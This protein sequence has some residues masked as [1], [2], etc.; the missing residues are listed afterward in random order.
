MKVAVE[1]EVCDLDT[2]RNTIK[3]GVMHGLYM[4]GD[5]K[6]IDSE[7]ADE[8]HEKHGGVLKTLRHHMNTPAVESIEHKK[9]FKRNPRKHT[10]VVG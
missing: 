1:F 3:L 5:V 4:D 10:T 8:R 7:H 6:V 2:L 9:I